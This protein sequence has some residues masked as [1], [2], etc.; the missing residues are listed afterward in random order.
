MLQWNQK[1]LCHNN[2]IDFQLNILFFE[3]VKNP[4]NVLP[5]LQSLFYVYLFFYTSQYNPVYNSSMALFFNNKFINFRIKQRIINS[6]L[7]S[8]AARAKPKQVASTFLS[9]GERFGRICP[10]S[11]IHA[12]VAHTLYCPAILRQALGHMEVA[13]HHP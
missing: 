6:I 3:G 13:M 1:L 2:T 12:A 9:P 11:C 7:Q 5:I 4:Q 8:S 10:S